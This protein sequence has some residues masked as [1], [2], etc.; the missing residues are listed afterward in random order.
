LLVHCDVKVRVDGL[1]L[2]SLSLTVAVFFLFEVNSDEHAESEAGHNSADVVVELCDGSLLQLF[3]KLIRIASS[4]N[5]LVTSCRF[6]FKLHTVIKPASRQKVKKA[7]LFC[8]LKV[9]FNQSYEW[10]FDYLIVDIV[11]LII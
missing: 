11:G 4:A 8:Y 6:H 7:R 3:Q 10:R 9:I 1:D 2:E 5:K